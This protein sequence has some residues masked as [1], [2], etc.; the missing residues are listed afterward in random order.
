MASLAVRAQLIAMD[1]RVTRTATIRRLRELQGCVA[2][3]AGHLGVLPNQR[4][5]RLGMFEL[6]TRG[7]DLPGIG[8]MALIA[9]DGE[10]AVRRILR[11]HGNGRETDP[12][13]GK[14]ELHD[15]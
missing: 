8:V 12:R 13:D 15:D 9:R 14:D 7:Q 5:P 1:I 3:P 10:F 11:V 2:L 4:E 6:H